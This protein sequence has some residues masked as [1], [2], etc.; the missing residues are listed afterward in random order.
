MQDWRERRSTPDG[1]SEDF[2]TCLL[3]E[4]CKSADGSFQRHWGVVMCTSVAVAE[5]E[6][7]LERSSVMW[8]RTNCDGTPVSC[9]TDP[10]LVVVDEAA[11]AL[12]S[13]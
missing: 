5:V 12:F 8:R 13:F 10:I 9:G 7:Q 1:S 3:E 6:K 4:D 11:E 2:R